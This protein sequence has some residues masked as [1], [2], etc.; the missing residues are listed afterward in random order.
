MNH[1]SIIF[2]KHVTVVMTPLLM[3]A[4]HDLHPFNEIPND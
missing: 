3:L 4:G 2:L 1:V